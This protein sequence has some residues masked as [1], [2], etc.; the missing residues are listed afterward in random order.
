M[1]RIRK[2]R[3]G[4]SRFS[5]NN[6]W[7]TQV[8][9]GSLRALVREEIRDDK[10][11]TL[12]SDSLLNGYLNEA[13]DEACRRAKLLVDSTDPEFVRL[14]VKVGQRV[15]PINPRVLIVRRVRMLSKQWTLDGLSVRDMDMRY[16]RWETLPDGVPLV[17]VTDFQTQAIAL[18]P[19]PDTADTLTL[20]VVRL[21][22]EDMCADDAEPEIRP[23]LHRKLVHWAKYRA[24]VKPDTDFYDPKTAADEL[25]LFEQE[26][27]RKSSAMAEH[28]MQTQQDTDTI[29][30]LV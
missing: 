5:Q 15:V 14:R 19:A 30:A 8:N 6:A 13:Q 28:W 11:P 18:H 12:F 23:D 2:V 24:M 17:Y 16:P 29:G 21:P 10:L 25:R 27:G 3:R 22:I 20:T 26:F 7:L 1:T 9:L 4:C